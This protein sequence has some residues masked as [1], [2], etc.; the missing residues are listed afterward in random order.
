MSKL[1]EVFDLFRVPSNHRPGL[2]RYFNRRDIRPISPTVLRWLMN[3][4]FL[5]KARIALTKNFLEN[6]KNAA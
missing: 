5:C 3:P 1:R 4:A 6:L 2:T